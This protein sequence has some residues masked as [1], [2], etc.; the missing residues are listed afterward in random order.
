MR[1]HSK[2]LANKIAIVTLLVTIVGIFISLYNSNE[3]KSTITTKSGDLSI[4]YG[5]NNSNDSN[6]LKESVSVLLLPKNP[7]DCDFKYNLYVSDVNEN[8][9]LNITLD[10][11]SEMII[12]SKSSVS[13]WKNREAIIIPNKW[14]M[15]TNYIPKKGSYYIFGN[16]YP[17]GLISKD[18]IKK[19][20]PIAIIKYE[21]RWM[22]KGI[23]NTYLANGI[24][25]TYTEIIEGD[26]TKQISLGYLAKYILMKML[27]M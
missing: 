24:N 17:I 22:T 15:Q 18:K 1:W 25:Y 7:T 27:F 2:T 23:N 4:I 16:K 21:V 13:I 8:L 5:N 12:S 9:Y 3:K 20:D 19:E 14:E 10:A 11:T 6:S 26:E